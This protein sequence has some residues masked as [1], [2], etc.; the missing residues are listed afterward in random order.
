MI[1]ETAIPVDRIKAFDFQ[2]ANG[3]A[4][5]KSVKIVT[6][7]PTDNY[8]YAFENRDALKKFLN[9]SIIYDTLNW[10]GG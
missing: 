5:G 3:G 8:L 7:D 10:D 1:G 4:S 2:I 6:D 9:D